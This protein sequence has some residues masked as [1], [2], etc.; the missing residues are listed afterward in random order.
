MKN[1][2]IKKSALA[3]AIV[4]VLASSSAFATNGLA[5]TGLGQEH[6]AMGG[7]AT[8]N[9]VNTMSM[10]TNPAAGSFI[11]DGWDI[12]AEIFQPVRSAKISGSGGFLDGNFDGNEDSAFL[13]PEG[14]YKRSIGDYAVGVTVY[15]NGGMNASYSAA[16]NP[17]AP[18]YAAN[19]LGAAPAAGVDFSQLFIAPT[20]SKKFGNQSIG[21]S[22]NLVYQ[23]F[24]AKGILPFAGF[25]SDPSNLTDKGYDSSTGIGATLG[26]QAKVS[27]NVMVGASYR[28]KVDMGKLDKYK[29]LFPNQGEFDVPANLNV[30]FSWKASPKTTIAA[31]YS[32]IYYSDIN[33]IGNPKALTPGS[34]GSNDGPGF[35]WDDQD[36]IKVGVKHQ[37]TP[38]F[39]FMAGYNHGKQPVPEDRTVLNI[40]APAVVEDHLAVGGEWKLNDKSSITASYIH[41]F[42]N[43]LEGKNSLAGLGL[44]GEADLTMHQNA[45]GVGYSRKF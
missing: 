7:A 6:K 30:G 11:E 44:P 37:F 43:T 28:T 3:T 29:G 20:V 38:K 15:G 21:I 41:T 9:P 23:R 33:A 13:I 40:L 2:L 25:S 12:G 27:D 10:A 5:P 19:G 32:H 18:L 36:I 8:A 24:E 34:L 31:D 17:F 1:K 39:A 14:G 22:A 35:G 42:K 4:A 45:I 26:W 16:N